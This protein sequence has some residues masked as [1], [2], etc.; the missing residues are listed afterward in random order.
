[1]SRGDG[2]SACERT[3]WSWDVALL[4]RHPWRAKVNLNLFS[5]NNHEQTYIPRVAIS[6]GWSALKY[7]SWVYTV[8]HYCPSD[9]RFCFWKNNKRHHHHLI[10]HILFLPQYTLWKCIASTRTIQWFFPLA[11]LHS[12]EVTSWDSPRDEHTSPVGFPGPNRVAHTHTF[13]CG[14]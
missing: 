9:S 11:T 8:C 7:N 3:L 12:C 1:M 10:G 5:S 13:N 14:P 6:T 4:K 2:S